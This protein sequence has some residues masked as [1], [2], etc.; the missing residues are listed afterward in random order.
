[1][2]DNIGIDEPSKKI[3]V[4]NTHLGNVFNYGYV[5]NGCVTYTG[6]GTKDMA[7]Q[8]C[9]RSIQSTVKLSLYG[10]IDKK[11]KSLNKELMLVEN[12]REKVPDL[13]RLLQSLKDLSNEI[14]EIVNQDISMVEKIPT[15]Y[16]DIVCD[17]KS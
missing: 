2:S 10:D 16:V 7:R 15:D 1:M 8:S 14:S 4:S 9:L 17:N 6:A 5:L 11:L 3:I 12:L 13:E